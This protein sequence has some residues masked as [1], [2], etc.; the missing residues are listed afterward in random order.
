MMVKEP[1]AGTQT[2][3]ILA[4]INELGKL[5][6]ATKL[7]RH[8]VRLFVVGWSLIVSLMRLAFMCPEVQRHKVRL[9]VVGWSLIVSVKRYALCV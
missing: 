1:P 8:K 6:W 2:F 7:K 4:K 9:F 3:L 5:F